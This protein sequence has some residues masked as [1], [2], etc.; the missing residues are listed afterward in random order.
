MIKEEF[1]YPELLHARAY[2]SVDY[3]HENYPERKAEY[4]EISVYMESSGTVYINGDAHPIRRCDVRFCRPGDT[5]RS[6]IP[7]HSLSLLIRFGEY[8]TEYNRN[9][10]DRIPSYFHADEHTITLFQS[11]IDTYS[12]MTTGDKVSMNA[13]LFQLLHHLFTLCEQN[14]TVPPAVALCLTHMQEHYDQKITLD[15]LGELTGYAPLHVLRLFKEHVGQTPCEYL[16]NLRMLQAR[17]L[18]DTTSLSVFE[19][20]NAVGFS[21]HSSFQALFKK[22]FGISPGKYRK[23]SEIILS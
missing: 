11:I 17:N 1:M 2:R 19:I 23:R 6:D 15:T 10:M 16:Q 13:Y 9:F 14:R 5:L 21:S 22:T 3:T 4:F 20:T 18:L 8:N 12:S 7:F